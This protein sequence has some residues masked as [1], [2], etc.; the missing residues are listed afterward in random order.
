MLPRELTLPPPPPD[1]APLDP[2]KPITV[3]RRFLPHW[4]QDGA[5]YA[6]TFRTADSLPAAKLDLLRRRREQWARE[7][8]PLEQQD[9]RVRKALE[10]HLDMG[11]GRC[12]LGPAS[13]TREVLSCLTHFDRDRYHLFAAV[14]M[15]NH[16][17]AVIR[18]TTKM[19]ESVLNGIKASSA[20]SILGR[21]G[22]SPPLWQREYYD[23][24]IR[25]GNHLWRCVQYLGWNVRKMGDAERRLRVYVRPDWVDAGW[26]VRLD[27]LPP[28][29]GGRA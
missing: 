28:R 2:K 1:F 19:L 12:L 16:V 9:E 8:V 29:P 5:T 6:V 17:H 20:A 27:A 13:D 14:V 18:P 4:R 26:G 21:T 3:Y 23:R 24:L 11:H 25:D 15:P 22:E 10:D 7:G